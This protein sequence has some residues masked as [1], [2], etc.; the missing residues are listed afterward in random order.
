MWLNHYES[1]DLTLDIELTTNCNAKC[2]QCSRTDQDNNLQKYSWLKLNQVSIEDWA[3]W[4][5]EED[6]TKIKR[7][8]F[9]G[10]YGDPGMCKDLAKIVDHIIN[11]SSA[12]VS[13]NTNGS[14]RDA[15]F[16]FDIGAVGQKRLKFIF[17][18]DGIDQEMHSFYRRGT[19]LNK[20]LENLEAAA[21]TPAEV[22]VLT[23]LFKHNEN[24]LEQIQDMCRELGATGFDSVEGNNFKKG[25]VYEFLNENGDTE[26]LEQV[27]NISSLQDPKRLS[28]RV[29]DHRHDAIAED[30]KCVAANGKNLKI[31]SASQVFPC[32][33]VSIA[34][35]WKT[36]VRS[37]KP[38]SSYITYTGNDGDS[39]SH[40]MQDYIDRKEDFMLSHRSLKEI[41]T[42][43]WYSENLKAS[44]TCN[45][46]FACSKVCGGAK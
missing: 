6:L 5:T 1:G 8:H 46:T 35:G 32:C 16:W 25:D 12:M 39:P 11:N 20:V 38:T 28:R 45:P 41:L 23:V 15:D 31:S 22:E 24:Y 14:M 10:T 9:S 18:V 19:N 3:S 7:F 40:L 21:M 44:F 29:R 42:D 2:P 37:G 17:D 36:G 13:I 30:I 26:V 33:Y 43:H 4:F 27:V 34:L